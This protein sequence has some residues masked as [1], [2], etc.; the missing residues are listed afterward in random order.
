MWLQAETAA[1]T[2]EADSVAAWQKV[3]AMEAAAAKQAANAE[4]LR[5]RAT[6]LRNQRPRLTYVPALSITCAGP[7]QAAPSPP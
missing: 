6:A 5:Q 4:Y 1:R 2:A 7:A 3:R